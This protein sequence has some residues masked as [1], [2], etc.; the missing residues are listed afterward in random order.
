MIADMIQQCKHELFNNKYLHIQ[1]WAVMEAAGYRLVVLC[2]RCHCIMIYLAVASASFL[3]P[4]FP[5]SS[6]LESSQKEEECVLLQCREQSQ[7]CIA[8]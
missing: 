6:F 3:P 4:F 1:G 7:L 2:T 8:K 5:P